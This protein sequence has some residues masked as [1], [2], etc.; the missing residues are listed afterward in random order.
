[1]KRLLAITVVALLFSV[2][3]LVSV[4]AAGPVSTPTKAKWTG[5]LYDV[6]YCEGSTVS[7]PII[8]DH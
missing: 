5:T 8:H 6:G 1:M 7:N 3:F 4:V 2:M